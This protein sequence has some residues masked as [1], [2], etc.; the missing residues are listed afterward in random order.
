[1]IGSRKDDY[2]GRRITL[3]ERLHAL[4]RD[5][6]TLESEM[7][8]SRVAH[9]AAAKE[10]RLMDKVDALVTEVEAH[11]GSARNLT[12]ADI[13]EISRRTGATTRDVEARAA[14]RAA[15]SEAATAFCR[16]YLYEEG[17]E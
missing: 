16:E 15:I 11:R 10:R 8:Y 4:E 6:R 14:R 13:E 17:D 9:L 7:R 1:M 2:S 3:Q 12:L 5:V